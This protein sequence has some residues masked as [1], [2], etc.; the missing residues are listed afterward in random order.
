MVMREQEE[1]RRRLPVELTSSERRIAIA[2]IDVLGPE[3]RELKEDVRE[4]KSDV[5]K[6]HVGVAKIVQHLGIDD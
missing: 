4:I 1:R 2:V 3:I 6:L 5:A